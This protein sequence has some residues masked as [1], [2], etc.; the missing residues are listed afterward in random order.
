MTALLCTGRVT[1][2]RLPKTKGEFANRSANQFVYPLYFVAWPLRATPENAERSRWFGFDR[3]APLAM[4][5]RDHGPCNGA[6][7]LP[8]IRDL[9]RRE[10]ITAADGEVV[11]QAFPRVFGLLFNPV[12]FWFCHDAAG[13]LRAVLAE[14]RNTFGERHNYLVA[15]ADQ[16]IIHAQDC[17]TARKV[18]HVS[19]FFPVSGEYRFR[20]ALS[21]HSRRVDID[22]FLDGERTLVTFVE[23]KPAPLTDQT[24]RSAALHF[25]LLAVGV[26]WRIH[27][28]ALR[29]WF[30]GAFF[31]RKPDLPLQETTR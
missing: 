19:P 12:S 11:L 17:L 8:W 31:F 2:A 5:A 28:Q 30:K 14:V 22:Y 16:G 24:A 13:G 7:L 20:F 1:H 6:P 10:G 21:E 23:G 27:W 4:H 29:L 3:R 26:V 9:L 25:P 18:F 15:H